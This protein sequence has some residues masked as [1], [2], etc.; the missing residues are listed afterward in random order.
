MLPRIPDSIETPDYTENYVVERPDY[1]VE[2]IEYSVER[3][4]Y[5]VENLDSVE[6]GDYFVETVEKSDYSVEKLDSPEHY[7]VENLG[8]VEH[9][10]AERL[11]LDEHYSVEKLGF[12]EN[13]FADFA[14]SYSMVPIIKQIVTI[15]VPVFSKNLPYRHC[16]FIGQVILTLFDRMQFRVTYCAVCS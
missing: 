5:S 10:F 3:L 7:F 8:S 6:K 14:E 13:Y 15:L 2:K 16:C 12:V 11:G 1:F 4:D 9:Y